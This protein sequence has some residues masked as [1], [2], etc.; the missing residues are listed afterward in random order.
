MTHTNI[1]SCGWRLWTRPVRRATRGAERMSQDAED[2]WG[3]TL[4]S[5][6]DR[7]S[8][9]ARVWVDSTRPIRFS[10]NTMVLAAPSAFAKEWLESRYAGTL[11]EA[12]RA[13]AGREIHLKVM[14]DAVPQDEEATHPITP[15]R[16]QAAPPPPPALNQRYLFETF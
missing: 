8:P 4:A 13:T 11:T 16:E 14:V 15:L 3:R 5:V 10:D 9:S 1:H 12:L 7:V 6:R 2:L